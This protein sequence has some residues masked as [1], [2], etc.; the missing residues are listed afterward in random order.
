MLYE[1]WNKYYL[2]GCCINLNGIND[3]H[4]T[5][6]TTFFSQKGTGTLLKNATEEAYRFFESKEYGQE[7][8]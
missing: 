8:I 2:R 4:N 3:V 7:R 6:H 5:K 1:R